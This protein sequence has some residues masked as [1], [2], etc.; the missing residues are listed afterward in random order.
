MI[1]QHEPP[2]CCGIG[3]IDRQVLNL[4]AILLVSQDIICLA[5]Q[6]RHM[7]CREITARIMNTNA[8]HNKSYF[9]TDATMF[10]FRPVTPCFQL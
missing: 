7:G 4:L 2:R 1:G 6:S 8:L 10:S 3:I 5:S 9:I